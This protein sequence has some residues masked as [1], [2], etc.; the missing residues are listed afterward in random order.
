MSRRRGRAALGVV[1]VAGAVASLL[2]ACF[3]DYEVGGDAGGGDGAAQGD[4]GGGDAT[5]ASDAPVGVEAGGDATGGHDGMTGGDAAPGSD[6]GPGVGD[7]SPPAYDSPYDGNPLSN[8]VQV[9]GGTF[10]FQVEPIN[11][12]SNLDAQATLGYTIAIDRTEVTVG[13]FTRW[14]SAGKPVPCDGCTLDPGGP[15]VGVM[16]WEPS[17][18]GTTD[19]DVQAD[20]TYTGNGCVNSEVTF[21]TTDGYPVT[22]VTWPQAL[23]FCAWEHKR[24][25]T[26]TEWRFFA[27][28]GGTRAPYPW[29]G[30]QVDCMHV[31]DQ[32]CVFP[33][34]AGSATQGA[35][36]DGV[37]DLVG[38]L[39]EW[40]WDGYK[41]GAYSY[42][43]NAGLNYPGPSQDAGGHVY[44]DSNYNSTNIDS[45]LSGPNGDG[46]GGFGDCGFRCAKSLP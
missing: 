46:T 22:C 43:A 33:A 42:P 18:W 12:G 40:L 7:S 34:L 35:S 41:A 15:Y 4:S 2:A 31:V 20:N 32:G 9:D 37:L 17:V 19:V 28:G 45:T 8:M 16:L 39:S 6:A 23:A 14:V 1:V 44:V 11:A 21:G 36:K 38:S 27:T 24:L 5:M 13:D 30:T 29:S 3:P 26:D 10:Y 25:P